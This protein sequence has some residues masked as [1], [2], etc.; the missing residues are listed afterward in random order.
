MRRAISSGVAA[1]PPRGPREHDLPGEGKQLLREAPD[2]LVGHHAKEEHEGA[3]G[4]K[5]G[6]ERACAR[7]IVGSVEQQGWS[8][9]EP[10]QAPRPA[11]AREAPPGPG[12]VLHHRLPNPFDEWRGLSPLSVAMLAAQS[13]YAS[14]QFE[15]GLLLNNADSGVIVTTDQS[16]SP[17][18]RESMAAA[19]MERKRKAGTADRPLFLSN[20]VK[21]E[22]PTI[23]SADM[24]FLENRKFK[25]QEI[26]AIFK[27]PQE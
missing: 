25:R 17:E 1:R 18:Q 10:L 6:G 14:A 12:E 15:K 26:C 9:R 16:L 24:Q 8:A 22:K 5:V 3:Q 21:V 19:L 4:A 2:V 23:S 11:H 13:D 7:G 20:G 27:V